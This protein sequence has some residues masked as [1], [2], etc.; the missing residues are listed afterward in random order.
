[1]ALSDGQSCTSPC[2]LSLP[3]TEQVT[4]RVSKEGCR[5]TQE[6]LYSLP[7]PGDSGWF[8]PAMLYSALDYQL[9]GAYRLSPDPLEVTLFC[10]KP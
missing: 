4:A 3:R 1:V 7:P 2:T 5:P 9:G 8:G 10:D 6:T